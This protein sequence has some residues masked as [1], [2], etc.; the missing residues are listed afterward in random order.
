MELGRVQEHAANVTQRIL[1]R[2]AGVLV[3][4]LTTAER[5]HAGKGHDDG[6]D[7]LSSDLCH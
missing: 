4:A 1:E 3:T 2:R 5:R 7:F 6:D